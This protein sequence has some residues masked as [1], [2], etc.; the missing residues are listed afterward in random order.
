MIL[1]DGRSL[2]VP[3]Q[4]SLTESCQDHSSMRILNFLDLIIHL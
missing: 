1:Y 4:K 2:S 3:S